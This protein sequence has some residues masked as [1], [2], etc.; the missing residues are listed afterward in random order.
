[1][2][3]KYYPKT[4]NLVYHKSHFSPPNS[5][6]TAGIMV[7]QFAACMYTGCTT[8]SA[9]TGVQWLAVL[10]IYLFSKIC[11][12]ALQFL[13]CK[14]FCIC[15]FLWTAKRKSVEV[16]ITSECSQALGIYML[17][18]YVAS[19][20]LRTDHFISSEMY[21]GAGLGLLFPFQP[22][23]S[24]LTTHVHRVPGWGQEAEWNASSLEAD[25]ENLQT[26]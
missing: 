2:M 25:A 6:I 9:C 21:L 12:N 16:T 10:P 8:P 17:F 24:F 15:T 26:E 7:T 22:A 11:R 3:K 1:M 20:S 18:L 19:K 5:L 13:E 23:W 4:E 14:D